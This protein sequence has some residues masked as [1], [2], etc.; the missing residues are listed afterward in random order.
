M[1]SGSIDPFRWN[2]LL[3]DDEGEADSIVTSLR[4]LTACGFSA[5]LLS[6][7]RE[8]KTAYQT[9]RS[10][11]IVLCDMH[12]ET[13]SSGSS[14][15]TLPDTVTD[16]QSVSQWIEA[17]EN[18]TNVD[19]TIARQSAWPRKSIVVSEVGLWLAAMVTHA[20][21]AT[22]IVFY[23]SRSGIADAGPLAA[24]GRFD[25]A[26]FA[27]L[28]KPKGDSLEPKSLLPFLRDA[29]RFHL[30]RRDDI[31]RWFLSCVL[32]PRL[33]SRPAV[34]RQL[35]ALHSPKECEYRGEHFFPISN[36][37]SDLVEFLESPPPPA[38]L[39]DSGRPVAK[40]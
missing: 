7:P 24:L 17:V 3:L 14:T 16:D 9:L 4:S 5:S 39:A 40:A 25:G 35:P 27:V 12:W 29:Q 19:S 38:R 33:F 11:D 36:D 15:G 2:V 32:I 21:P 18:W 23:S 8:F 1:T 31:R 10:A 6:S 37:I 30:R 22:Q 34:S 20:N 13:F 28:W 26:K